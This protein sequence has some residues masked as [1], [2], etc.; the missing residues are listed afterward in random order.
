ML[1]LSQLSNLLKAYVDSRGISDFGSVATLTA[2]EAIAVGKVVAIK[3]TGGNEGRAILADADAASTANV[4]GICISAAA[5]QGDPCIVAQVGTMGGFSGLTAGNKLYA[6]TT[7]GDLTASAPG[8]TGDVIFQ[9]G[10]A[11]S[12]T[13]III[14]PVYVMELG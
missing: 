14:Q 1:L 5:A 3:V 13:T 11:I 7:A 8:G 4:V 6:S 12:T 9:V 10:F 2:D